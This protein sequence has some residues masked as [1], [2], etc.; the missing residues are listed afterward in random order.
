MDRLATK[1]ETV[2][3]DGQKNALKNLRKTIADRKVFVLEKKDLEPEKRDLI[4]TILDHVIARVDA[5]SK[6]PLPSAI[7]KKQ[8]K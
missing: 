3:A 2:S 4:V 5:L 8:S 1:L 6:N 7:E